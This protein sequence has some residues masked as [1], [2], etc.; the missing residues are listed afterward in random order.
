MSIAL[1]ACGAPPAVEQPPASEAA[2]EATPPKVAPVPRD[3]PAIVARVNDEAIES[4]EI[5]AALREIVLSSLHPVPQ[6]ERDELVRALLDRIVEHHL[7]AQLARTR[8]LAVSDAELD[9]DL[10]QMRQKYPNDRAFDDTLAS[11]GVSREQLRHQRRLSLDM[12]KLIEKAIAPTSAVSNAEV[13]AYYRDNPQ[14]F[15]IPES[16]IARHI[17][18]RVEPN[19][20]AAQKAEARRR[21]ADIL[22]QLR[23]GADFA[24]LA[25]A[26]SEDTGSAAAGG[27]LGAF[28]RGQME[29]AF[30]AAAFAVK[31]G[32]LSD[33]VETPYGFHIIRVDEHVGG[34]MQTFDDVRE[35]IKTLLSDRAEEE[36]LAKLIEE[37]KRTAKIEIYI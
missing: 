23:G 24:K 6:S 15:Q 21:A 17:L 8:K 27:L 20:T 32:E 14:R 10:R 33:L 18:I 31:T 26:H 29:P 12:A 22:E 34:R 2:R 13:A 7:A 28:P 4:W 1:L 30:D 5:E 25:Q 37:A 9:A 11:Y 19:A 36:A 3:L 16:V 35:D